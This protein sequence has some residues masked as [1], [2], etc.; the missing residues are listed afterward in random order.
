MSE[1][2]IDER[3]QWPP[4]KQIAWW[5]NWIDEEYGLSNY[6]QLCDEI[7]R[8]GNAQKA[9]LEAIRA[10]VERVEKRIGESYGFGIKGECQAMQDELAAMEKP[11]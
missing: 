9:E 4:L 10:I 2:T 5:L 3:L 11:K 1:P 8:L 6:Q 7:E